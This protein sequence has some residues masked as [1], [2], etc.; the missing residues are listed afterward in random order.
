M[1][2]LRQVGRKDTCLIRI[3]NHPKKVWLKNGVLQMNVAKRLT[4]YM[5]SVRADKRWGFHFEE[6]EVEQSKPK[7]SDVQE[8]KA[9]SDNSKILIYTCNTNDYD[10]IVE[11]HYTNPNYYFVCFTNKKNPISNVFSFV[12]LPSTTGKEQ[13]IRLARKVKLQIHKYLDLDQYDYVVWIDSS[14]ALK[15]SISDLTNSLGENK[16]GI[17]SHNERNCIYKEGNFCIKINKDIKSIITKQLKKY[18]DENFPENYGLW[19][20]HCIVFKPH[21]DIY[22]FFDAWYEEVKNGSKRDQISLPYA[23]NKRNI[24]ISTL[25]NSAIH[26]K[27]WKNYI[28]IANHRRPKCM[29]RL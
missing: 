19:A 7:I 12:K 21:K 28:N 8:K 22:D 25:L 6:E 26:D 29:R 24:K 20:T 18:R 9:V 15:R 27:T 13:S 1:A 2:I 11:N 23:L 17:F 5:T 16:I 10:H 14:C 4:Q 3:P